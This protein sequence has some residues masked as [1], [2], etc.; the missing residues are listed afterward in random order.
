MRAVERSRKEVLCAGIHHQEHFGEQIVKQH[1]RLDKMVFKLRF[2]LC[3]PVF[4][5][6]CGVFHA[7]IRR[8]RLKCV[9]CCRRPVCGNYPLAHS[10]QLSAVCILAWV[11]R[12]KIVLPCCAGKICGL[13]DRSVG[14]VVQGFPRFTAVGKAKHIRSTFVE[15]EIVLAPEPCFVRCRVLPENHT[16]RSVNRNAHTAVRL[17]RRGL[18][19][20]NVV[21]KSRQLHVVCALAGCYVCFHTKHR[22]RNGI[23]AQQIAVRLNVVCRI[24]YAALELQLKVLLFV[25]SRGSALHV[26]FYVFGCK[27]AAAVRQIDVGDG[28]SLFIAL[29]LRQLLALNNHVR[30]RRRKLRDYNVLRQVKDIIAP[31]RF[32]TVRKQRPV[33]DIV[34]QNLMARQPLCI[35]PHF[36]NVNSGGFCTNRYANSRAL[37][38]VVVLRIL[39][40]A[41][42][43]S[44]HIDVNQ[45]VQI[46]RFNHERHTHFFVLFEL[47]GH[48]G[49]L[50]RDLRVLRC[51]LK[52]AVATHAAHNDAVIVADIVR[53]HLDL[54]GHAGGTGVILK[55]VIRDSHR[56]ARQQTQ[57][58]CA[59]AVRKPSVSSRKPD[60]GERCGYPTV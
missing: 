44:V 35:E 26:D 28:A 36:V 55:Q 39:N 47:H 34:V 7:V 27:A 25:A 54:H 50:R 12:L 41:A 3:Q 52:A 16:R 15:I 17:L 59:V 31:E 60:A 19:R 9:S 42:H 49:L 10:L 43:N 38:K 46:S 6:I 32:H 11:S 51:D 14:C 2:E 18:V 22:R 37:R 33:R 29:A 53:G 13:V 8:R 45:A 48:G 57:N 58:R 30:Q 21:V 5:T 40:R 23:L 24:G 56:A 4:G 1:R 20:N